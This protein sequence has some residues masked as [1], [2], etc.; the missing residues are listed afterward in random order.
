MKIYEF[1]QE[2]RDCIL[3]IHPSLVTWDY[4]DYVISLLE[5]DFHLFV[6]AVPGYDMTDDS[7]FTS[8]EKIASDLADELIGKGIRELKVAYGCSMGAASS[9]GWQSMGS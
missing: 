5:N 7:Q 9:F 2:N 1:G 3:L 8:V 4:F 6:P